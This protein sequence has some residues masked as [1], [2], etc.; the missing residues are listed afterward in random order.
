MLHRYWFQLSQSSD[1]SILNTGCGITAE[2]IDDAKYILETHVFSI[3]GKRDIINII[4][5]VDISDLDAGVVRPNMK[6]PV[7]RG[8]WFPIL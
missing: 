5:N 3:Y 2:S 7:I 4:E 8:V 6:L 1:P